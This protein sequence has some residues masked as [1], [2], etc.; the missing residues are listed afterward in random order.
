[1]GSIGRPGGGM[2]AE[3]GHANIQGNTDHAISWELLPGYMKVPAPG[4]KNRDDYVTQ[5]AATKSDPHSWNF[6]GIN[7]KKFL[8]SLLKAWYGDAATASN[9]FAFDFLPKPATNSS[10]MSIYDQALK[11]RMQGVILSGMTAASIGPDANQVHQAL[12]NLKWLVVMDALPT[13]SSEFWHAP[14]VD[15]TKIQTEVFLVPSTHWIE[16]EGSFTNS[17]R[18]A[19]WKDRVLPPQGQARDDHLVLAD[20]FQRVKKLYQSQ[21]GKFPDPILSVTFGYQDPT[22]PTLDEIAKE[23]NG[24]DLTAGKQMTTFANLKDD[25]TTTAGDWIYTGSYPD[26]GNLM[27]R[28]GGI[29]DP[30]TNDPTGMGF[31]PNWAWSWP[32]NRRVLYNR[33]SADLSGQPWDPTRPGI[34]WNGSKWVGDV[35]DYPPTMS[36][37]D[38]NAY[39][40]FIMN[41]EGVGRLFSNGMVD[42]PF[43]EHY[44]PVESPVKNPLHASNSADPVAFYYDQAAGRLNRFGTVTD[45]P[46]IATTYR[47]TEH[48]HYVTQH[49]PHLV[50]LQPKPFVEIPMELANEKGIKNGDMVRV[51]SKRGKVEVNAIVTKRLGSMTVAGQKVFQIGIPIHWGYVGIP[52]DNDPSHGRY[53]V[54]NA[55]TPFVGDANSRTPEFK[56][57]LVNLEKI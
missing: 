22:K 12:A 13:T 16:K 4:Q 15:S 32:L 40:P 41:G 51:S 19:Q 24:R 7:Y 9:E 55:L 17:G 43:P 56:A 30:K 27:K 52:A 45:F 18:W 14:G 54:A 50:Q 31:Y 57:F 2:N 38:P 34:T 23:I 39:L 10:W 5:S 3:R 42:G 49:V 21:G 8:T 36:P 29:Q 20:I 26:G 53:W 46:Y 11:G 28:R 33:A 35:P 44:E 25:G 47:L 6:F 48:E 1:M 37:S